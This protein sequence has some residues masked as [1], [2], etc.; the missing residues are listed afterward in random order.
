MKPSLRVF[1]IFTVLTI[2]SSIFSWQDIYSIIP[3]IVTV[4][5]TYGLW[6]NNVKI[7][8]GT[9][10][11]AGLGWAIYD[12]I[13]MA[14]VGAVQEVLQLISAIIAIIR[15]KKKGESVQNCISLSSNN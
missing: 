4:I 13:V 10:G 14:Y 7:L 11:I 15:L 5:H 2:I 9:V 6:Q 12:I 8:K 1:I 3:L